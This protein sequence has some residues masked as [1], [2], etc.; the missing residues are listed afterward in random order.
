MNPKTDPA[1]ESE[2]LR[3]SQHV[4]NTTNYTALLN[5]LWRKRDEVVS[6]NSFATEL[7]HSCDPTSRGLLYTQISRL[8]DEIDRHNEYYK[9]D[10]TRRYIIELPKGVR[11]NGYRLKITN[12]SGAII[13][14][15][16]NAA[17]TWKPFVW[18]V[19]GYPPREIPIHV[20]LPETG[21]NFTQIKFIVGSDWKPPSGFTGYFE[22]RA[23]YFKTLKHNDNRTYN[24][25]VWRVDGVQVDGSILHV[26]VQPCR[27]IDYYSTCQSLDKKIT[28]DN[29]TETTIKGWLAPYWTD[30]S[31]QCFYP[32]AGNLGVNTLITTK[33]GSAVVIQQNKLHPGSPLEWVASTSGG[34]KVRSDTESLFK[35]DRRPDPRRAAQV[36]ALEESGVDIPV[37]RLKWVAFGMG[38]NKG[39]P[40]LLGEVKVN[41]TQMQMKEEDFPDRE[42]E[43]QLE[44]VEMD[45]VTLK[46]DEIIS[47]LDDQKRFKHK[48]YF[49]LAFALALIRREMAEQIFT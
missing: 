35:K 16:T 36:E 27:W 18:Q 17:K 39:T 12:T 7:F 21:M 5:A 13:E 47:I 46:P 43:G 41:R 24:G 19:R 1:L 20:W 26:R 29:G 40:A 22:H 14:S 25:H 48:T 6:S 31:L 23:E 42:G 32:G 30:C 8:K 2:F 3:L 34:V 11:G 37:E 33:E 28:L 45:F 38:L 4:R 15:E 9:V 49:E 10:K 44:T